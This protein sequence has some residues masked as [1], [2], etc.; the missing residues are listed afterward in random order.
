MVT[1]LT[2]TGIPLTPDAMEDLTAKA[3]AVINGLG[4]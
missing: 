4:N 3:D 2:E 1:K